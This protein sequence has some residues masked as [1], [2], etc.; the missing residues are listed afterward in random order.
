MAIEDRIPDF[1]DKDLATL[2]ANARRLAEDGEGR[3]RDDAARL[4]P[5]IEA[6][7]DGRRARAP[8]PP[9]RK[10]PVR[11]AAAAPKAAPKATPRSP[12]PRAAKT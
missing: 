12:K 8:A 9:A 3:R 2:L 6:E 7:L 10:P 4:V 11:K 5:L 1:S